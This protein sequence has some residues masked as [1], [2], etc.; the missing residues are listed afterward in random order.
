MS[1]NSFVFYESFFE[2]IRLLPKE[3]S[4]EAY[5]AIC[6]YALYG[7]EPDELLPGT[8]IVF[9][10]VKPQ[11]D[12]NNQRRSNGEKGGRPK[13]TDGLL[14]KNQRLKKE[15]PN[16]NVNGN[17]NANVNVNEYMGAFEETWQHYPRKKEKAAAYKAY[18]ARLHEYSPEQLDI[19]V[20]RYAEECRILG[21]EERYIKH[22]AT[23]FG[24][25]M[26]FTD[27]LAE[28]YRPPDVSTGRKMEPVNNRFNNFEQRT[29]SQEDYK[30]FEQAMKKRGVPKQ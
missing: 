29:Y 25:S 4:L 2:A 11:I 26:P 14:K 15:K 22:G 3:E 1:N 19:A 24:P 21:T 12:A 16:V 10:L 17:V 5:D 27:Y 30:S 18:K 7:E 20:K 28:D 23:F 8:E 9:T 13:K 6:R